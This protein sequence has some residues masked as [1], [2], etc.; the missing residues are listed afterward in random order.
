MKRFHFSLVITILLLAS[1]PLF[2]AD[3]DERKRT[4]TDSDSSPSKPGQNNQLSAQPKN[5]LCSSPAPVPI[6]ILGL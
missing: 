2:A 4:H 6:P 3:G 1:T 5:Y